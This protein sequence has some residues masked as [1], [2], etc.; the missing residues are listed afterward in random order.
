MEFTNIHLVAGLGFAAAVVLGAVANRTHF[1]TMGAV[2]DWLNMGQKGRM[3]AWALAIGIA[4]AGAQ[5][6]EMTG[7]V[8]LKTSLYRAPDLGI[9]GY[10][11]GGLL[12]G[13]GMTLAGGCGQRSLVR[14]GSGNLKSVV[15]VLVLGVSAYMTV[16][17]LLGLVRLEVIEPLGM[18]LAE[19][20]IQDQ[21][22]ATVIASVF[23]LESTTGLRWIVAA[24]V[25]ALFILWA[26]KQ[27]DL[28][29]SRD[30][31]LSGI[32]LGFAVIAAWFITGNIGMDDFDPVPVEGMTFI[33][34]T[35]NMVNYLMSFTGATINFGIAI[36]FGMLFG[37][38]LY[39]VISKTFAIETFSDRQDMI[40]TL[41]GA[42]IMGFG[43]VLARGCTIGQGV[44]GISTLAI[45][46]FI[47]VASI[48]AGSVLTM[49]IQYHLMDEVGF[50]TALKSS[51][52]EMFIP[53]R[54]AE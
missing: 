12:F 26:L 27:K 41:F 38:F 48:I 22:L 46:S 9:A 13:I 53:G 32:V 25:A 23:G 8:D 29:E 42:V 14:A 36:V 34:P 1:C 2:S 24:V 51:L 5:V 35:G 52:A 47:A 11:V 37:S 18:D 7:L 19:R 21:G 50:G 33:A 49:K 3:A 31:I 10:I 17:G 43:G 54:S 6:L 20:E 4:I 15:V 40:N 44:S 39:G 28:R 30:G 16:R 45:G